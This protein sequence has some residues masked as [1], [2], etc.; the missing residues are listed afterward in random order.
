AYSCRGPSSR[1][2]TGA[3]RGQSSWPMG[4]SG[5]FRPLNPEE[6]PMSTTTDL[7]E[8]SGDKQAASLNQM[9][10]TGLMIVSSGFTLYP[11]RIVNNQ[12]MALGV[13]APVVYT[14]PNT[15]YLAFPKD[16]VA[17]TTGELTME[18]RDGLQ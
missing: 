16:S 18:P 12:L 3:S 8:Q 10:T 9:T 11:T 14:Y 1:A 5:C 15:P 6:A 4:R 13:A 17:S 7:R 2:A